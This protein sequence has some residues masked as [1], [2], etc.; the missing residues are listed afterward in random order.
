MVL[1]R[2]IGRKAEKAKW[3]RT[4]GDKGFEG[5]EKN[6]DHGYKWHEWKRKTLL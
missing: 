5:G 6:N 1:K 2:P 3:K 4:N